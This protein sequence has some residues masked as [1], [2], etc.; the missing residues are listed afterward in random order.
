M[1]TVC[2]KCTSRCMHMYGTCCAISRCTVHSVHIYT[3]VHMYT[4]VLL[5]NNVTLLYNVI[6]QLMVAKMRGFSLSLS[7][8]FSLPPSPSLLSCGSVFIIATIRTR[9]HIMF[10]PLTSRATTAVS[11]IKTPTYLPTYSRNH[12]IVFKHEVAV[13]QFSETQAPH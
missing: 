8:S 5:K 10:T 4:S 9:F 1:D 3:S 12:S 7:L 13:M 6:I 2:E 11:R